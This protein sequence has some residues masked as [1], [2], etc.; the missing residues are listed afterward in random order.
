[1][2]TI[3]IIA[4]ALTLAAL[5]SAESDKEILPDLIEM[6]KAEKKGDSYKRKISD[7]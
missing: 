2:K 6:G 3:F 5:G 7:K 1:M 4:L